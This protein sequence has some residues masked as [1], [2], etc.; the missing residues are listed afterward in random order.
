[1]KSTLSE[2]S[3]RA[4]CFESCQLILS[5]KHCGHTKSPTHSSLPLSAA[6][7]SNLVMLVTP[8]CC[9]WKP[10]SYRCDET[11]IL[12]SHA[13]ARCIR[14]GYPGSAALREGRFTCCVSLL[15]FSR[16]PPQ[17]LLTFVPACNVHSP[18]S[19]Q[20]RRQCLRVA[21]TFDYY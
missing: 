16:L 14:Y 10:A 9:L 20:R 4:T 15:H 11:P 2:W 21:S 19:I 12:S 8:P 3:P 17:T 13:S 1:M 5:N 18:T 7:P 6:L